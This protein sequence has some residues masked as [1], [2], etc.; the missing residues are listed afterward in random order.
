MQNDPGM[1]DTL[2]LT[3]ELSDSRTERM[4]KGFIEQLER[5]NWMLTAFTK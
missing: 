5:N 2:E 4:L 3:V 1:C